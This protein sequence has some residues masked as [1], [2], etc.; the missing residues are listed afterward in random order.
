MKVTEDPWTRGIVFDGGPFSRG[1]AVD[2]A[3]K[4]IQGLGS[5]YEPQV[6]TTDER[7]WARALLSGTSFLRWYDRR[8]RD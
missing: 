4:I 8:N 5:N 6:Y 3:E 7:E 2:A 1:A